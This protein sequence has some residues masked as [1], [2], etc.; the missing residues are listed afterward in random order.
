MNIET[1][2]EYPF[3]EMNIEWILNPFNKE[4]SKQY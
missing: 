1:D 4:Y 3:R 2:I